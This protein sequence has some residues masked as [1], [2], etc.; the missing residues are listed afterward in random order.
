MCGARPCGQSATGHEAGRD[1][2]R[3]SPLPF[4][5]P[6]EAPRRFPRRL[7]RIPGSA[8]RGPCKYGVILSASGVM[9]FSYKDKGNCGNRGSAHDAEDRIRAGAFVRRLEIDGPG[10]RPASGVGVCCHV[11]PILF[12]GMHLVAADPSISLVYEV[13][14]VVCALALA[15]TGCL[16]SGL[17]ACS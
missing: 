6:Q 7:P 3:V 1:G 9:G 13:S 11:R 17:R 10:L 15:T 4:G 2:S 12:P 16:I 8:C 5:H 14:V